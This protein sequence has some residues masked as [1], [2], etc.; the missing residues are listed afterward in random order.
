M[1]LNSIQILR[2][3]AALLVVYTHSTSQMGIFALGWQQRTPAFLSFGTFGFDLF[4]V[5]S[6]FIIYHTAERLNGRTDALSFLWHRFRRI[7]PVYYAAVLLTVLTWLPSLFRAQRPPITGCQTLSWLILLPFPGDPARALSQA[8]SLSFEWL[9]YLIF[10]LLI[11]TR[12]RKKA[13]LLGGILGGLALIGWLLRGRI[14]GLLLF[15]TDP[16]LLE[17]LFGVVIGFAYHHWN[18]GKMTALFLLLPGILLGLLAMITGDGN[19]QAVVAPAAPIRYF[20]AFYWGGAAALIVAGSAFLE[21]HNPSAAFLRHRFIVLLGDASYS[22]YLFHLLVLG[23]LAAFYLRVGFFLN[24]DVAIPI[25][26]IIAVAG[27]LF[28]Y[29]WVEKPLLRWLKKYDIGA[30]PSRSVK[31]TPSRSEKP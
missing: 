17:F 4:F 11:L 31:P 23:W 20:H 7:N 8:W 12:I 19:F 13:V 3:V 26:A 28:F 15:Y 25:H 1:K 27:S 30:T 14:T 21:K 5:I 6:G 16:L 2:A 9:F 22:I 10:F 29:K 24:P 18:P